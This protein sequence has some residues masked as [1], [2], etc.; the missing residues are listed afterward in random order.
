MPNL[1]LIE[2]FS[3][4][5][6]PQLLGN[7]FSKSV[8]ALQMLTI[9]QKREKFNVLLVGEPGTGK[10]VLGKY[11]SSALPRSKYTTDDITKVG[12][13][14]VLEYVDGGFLFADEFDKIPFVHRKRLLEAMQFG[15]TTVDKYR[16]HETVYSRVNVCAM[17]NPYQHRLNPHIPLMKQLPFTLAEATRFHL[18]IPFFEVD[19]A[20][21]PNIAINYGK[22]EDDSI[23]EKL[24]EYIIN[25]KMQIP[26]VNVKDNIREK[27]GNFIRYSKE[28]SEFRNIICPRAI[29]GML[30]AVQARARMRLR[31]EAKEEDYL[32]VKDIF[33]KFYE[34]GVNRIEMKV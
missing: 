4:L 18:F 24:R 1:K 3:D 26:E 20:L 22:Y 31:G 19:S 12:F 34:I 6:A 32:Y 15:T 5:I 30:S 25:L 21:Y 17:C 8:L 10:S 7:E 11:L 33:K 28:N 16:T 27:I 14:E 9:P 23:K 13:R 2:N 29:E